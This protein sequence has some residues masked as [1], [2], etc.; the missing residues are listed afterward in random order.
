MSKSFFS[1]CLGYDVNTVPLIQTLLGKQPEVPTL[2]KKK[3]ESNL[4]SDAVNKSTF[5]PFDLKI[6]ARN[7]TMW[8][9]FFIIKNRIGN[10]CWRASIIAKM[11]NEYRIS[12]I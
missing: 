9:F 2:P 8:F 7:I 12:L 11:L 1:G 3:K 4:G 6:R 10:I 5:H